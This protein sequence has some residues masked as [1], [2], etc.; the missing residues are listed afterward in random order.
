VKIKFLGHISTLIL[1]PTVIGTIWPTVSKAPK[2]NS[3]KHKSAKNLHK[4][5]TL[6]FY[7]ENV[8]KSLHWLD[9]A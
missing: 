7:L 8:L 5:I 9:K 4:Y 1:F 3:S 2:Q 6:C